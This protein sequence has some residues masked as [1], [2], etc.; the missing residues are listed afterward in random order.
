MTN[1]EIKNQINAAI[2]RTDIYEIQIELYLNDGCYHKEGNVLCNSIS[3]Y[4]SDN[5]MIWSSV[6]GITMKEDV[7]FETEETKKILKTEQKKMYNYLTKHFNNV[8]IEKI[9]P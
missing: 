9:T 5:D 4:N 3:V 8:S 2:K 7:I 1:I 6:Y